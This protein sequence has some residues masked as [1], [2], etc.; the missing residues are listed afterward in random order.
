[1]VRERDDTIDAGPAASP[2]SALARLPAQLIVQTTDRS[3]RGIRISLPPRKGG[4]PSAWPLTAGALRAGRTP[5]RRY[6]EG[7]ALPDTDGDDAAE[8]SSLEYV[9]VDVETTGGSAGY[10]DRITEFAAVRLDGR[11]R[12]VDEFC[13]L[14]NPDRPIPPFISRLTRITSRMVERA[15][16]FHDIA[17]DVNRILNGAIFVAHN[18]SFDWRFV[19]SEMTWAVGNPL[20]G[21]VLC[22]VRLARKVVPEVRSRS[23]DSLQYFFGVENEARHR[24]FGDARATA[25]IFRRMLERLDEREVTRW[26]ELETLLSRR[27]PR[28]KRRASPGPVTEI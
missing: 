12:R 21:R 1:V 6:G 25:R 15:P 3:T 4:P 14:L 7:W 10:G 27:A 16:R 22:T 5:P 17:D 26:G 23:L 20:R 8:L 2:P 19:S 13:T 18:A 28:R 9:V 11:G 24:A